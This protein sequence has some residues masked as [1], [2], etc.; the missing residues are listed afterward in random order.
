MKNLLHIFIMF[1]Y[2]VILYFQ[3]QYTVSLNVIQLI[4]NLQ[5]QGSIK[6]R[7]HSQNTNLIMS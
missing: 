5:K 2:Y 4:L 6:T 7:C 3:I 1:K